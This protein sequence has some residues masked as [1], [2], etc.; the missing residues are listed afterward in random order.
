MYVGKRL[1][2]RTAVSFQ[3]HSGNE[4]NCST[5]SSNFG[6]NGAIFGRPVFKQQTRNF[7]LPPYV[8]NTSSSGLARTYAGGKRKY[9][10]RFRRY[11][12][13]F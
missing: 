3:D 9:Q 11:V 1:T 4:S 12:D 7:G 2:W 10:V 13:T 5:L 6:Q 8:W